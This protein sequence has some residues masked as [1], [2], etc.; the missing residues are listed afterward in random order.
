MSLAGANSQN[1]HGDEKQSYFEEETTVAQWNRGSG[2]V[3]VL[4]KEACCE[5]SLGLPFRLP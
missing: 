2:S 4:T 5:Y 1:D 3:E